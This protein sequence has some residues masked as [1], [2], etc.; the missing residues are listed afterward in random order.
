MMNAKDP[1]T[2]VQCMLRSEDAKNRRTTAGHADWESPRVVHPGLDYSQFRI[3][4][5]Y[6][7]FHIILTRFAQRAKI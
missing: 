5:K 4:C 7:L 2:F 6:N 1:Q 3:S